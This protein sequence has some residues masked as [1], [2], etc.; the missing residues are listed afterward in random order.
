MEIKEAIEITT[1]LYELCKQNNR[2]AN[3]KDE[4]FY[5][6]EK[7]LFS[8]QENK[9]FQARSHYSQVS[10]GGMGCFNDWNPRSTYKNTNNKF[11]GQSFKYI[12]KEWSKVMR[13]IQ[14]KA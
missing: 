4:E 10:L 2:P 6:I 1:A 13:Q 8:L 3:E 14:D 12:A 5:S 7:C 11:S 9:L